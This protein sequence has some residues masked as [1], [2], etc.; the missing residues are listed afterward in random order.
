VKE[1]ERLKE[2]R[3]AVILAHNY[4]PPEIQDIADY[5][6]DSFGLSRKASGTD[7]DVIVF[8]GVDFMAETAKILSPGKTVL[9]P[10]P[11][12]VCPLAAMI[13]AADVR[14]LRK[15]NPGAPVVTYVNTSAAV[16]AESDICCTSSNL[17]KIVSGLDAERVIL[18]PDKHL[19]NYAASRTGKEVVSW[20]GYCPSH[21][22][23]LQEHIREQKRR[24]PE[25][26]VIVHPECRLDVI[27]LADEVTSTG[28]MVK[29]AESS[30]A[31]E[32]IIGTEVGMLYR[33]RKEMPGKEFYPATELAV[34]PNMKR[35]TLA[36]VLLSLREL[37][38]RVDVPEDVSVRA[39]HAL[40]RMLK[41]A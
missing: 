33:L 14:R 13:K 12:S 9:I 15:E 16:K 10:D 27:D 3:N 32:F 41:F 26:K 39:N 37:K 20:N 2:E 29:Y 40:D 19:A 30:P 35:T 1:I 5:L 21:V 8:C 38:H 18:I 25:A 11:S 22:K 28:G 24:H 31:R 6:G 7:A 36:K 17:L 23:I 34:C 4:Q